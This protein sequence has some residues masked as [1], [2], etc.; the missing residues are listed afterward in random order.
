MRI[1]IAPG[2]ESL[3]R[4]FLE[5]PFDGGR[6]ARRVEKIAVMEMVAEGL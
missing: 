1:A 6:H 5:T 3:T 2:A 4:I